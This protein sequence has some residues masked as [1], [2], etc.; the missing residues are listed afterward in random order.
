MFVYLT[1]LFVILACVGVTWRFPGPKTNRLC[2]IICC[3]L[4]VLVAGLRYR[5]G[6]DAL[7]Y[8]DLFEVYPKINKLTANYIFTSRWASLFVVWYSFWH[9]LFD[10]FVF[11]QF[12]YAII[13][14]N[15]VYIT[16]K[17]NT[18][19]IFCALAM[20]FVYAYPYF[21]FDL[22]REGLAMSFFLYGFY[23]LQKE[24][25][26]SYYVFA[27]VAY[28]I[29]PSSTFVLFVP[30]LQR[31]TL[32][33][34][35]AVLVFVSVL[36]CSLV[37][38]RLTIWMLHLLPS[39]GITY[40]ALRYLNRFDGSMG[41]SL[42]HVVYCVIVFYIAVY[43]NI[44][45]ARNKQEQLCFNLAFMSVLIMCLQKAV[46]FIFRLNTYFVFFFFIAVCSYMEHYL[47]QKK[48]FF[49]K[50]LLILLICCSVKI[51]DYVKNPTTFNAYIPYVSV[52]DA[53]KV[54]IRE[55]HGQWQF[56]YYD[57]Q[58]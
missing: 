9:T 42:A 50:F 24:K 3:L 58:L 51:M 11:Y 34:K 36:L 5:V 22:C 57:Q 47:L 7:L 13:L 30:L 8:Q 54:P 46:P 20:Y 35:K 2:G 53:H 56:L 15:A 38:F 1:V 18:K 44:G 33:K 31:L 19:L 41:F 6:T 25:I 27:V 37:A 52:F 17:N 39:T 45:M 29:H 28:F 16:L 23:F 43:K 21:T 55:W 12:I 14:T 48:I 10:S 40:L 4:L 26:I 32:T 49:V